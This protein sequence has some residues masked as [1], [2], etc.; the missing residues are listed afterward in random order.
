M[1]KS[2]TF[3]IGSCSISARFCKFRFYIYK[4]K[5]CI[6]FKVEFSKVPDFLK[7]LLL[8]FLYFLDLAGAGAY[9]IHLGERLK[10]NIAVF[11]AV[12][13]A[14]SAYAAETSL[15]VMGAWY[16]P[17]QS[18]YGTDGFAPP[19]FSIV[20]A[21][22]TVPA[23]RDLGTGL[24]SA[25]AKVSLSLTDKVPFLTGDDPLLSGNSMRGKFSL[26]MSPVS[27]NVVGQLSLTPVAFLVFDAGAGIGTGW[28]LGP[29]R[30]LGINPAGNVADDIDLTPFGGAVWRAWGAGTFQFDLATIASGE[31]NHVVFMATAKVEYKA[32]TGAETGEAWLWEADDGENFNGAKYY[33][34]Y[35]LA[36]QMPL[37]IN[38]AGILVESEEWLGE[39]RGFSPMDEAGAWGSDFRIW[40]IGTVTNFSLGANDSLAV[41]VQFKRK[42]DYTDAT[43]RLRD[44]RTRDY[45]GAYWFFNRV[46]FSYTHTFK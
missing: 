10:K 34:T 21:G 44:F 11:V 32:D 12:L 14:A 36:Y 25:E 28:T 4:Q 39:P 41:L 20:P 26:E 42:A 13:F 16:V 9:L 8:K 31:W 3:A 1:Q 27:M 5:Y 7:F 35:V 43:T 2:V 33:G 38:L 19:D 29:L 22:E 18:G 46:A 15:N 37:V 45:E 24:G 30:G 23:Q 6:T 40:Q 17:N